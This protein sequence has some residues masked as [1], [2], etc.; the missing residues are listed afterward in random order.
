MTADEL[1]S[2]FKNKDFPREKAAARPLRDLG[3]VSSRKSLP[4]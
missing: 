2:L 3:S 4:G 1:V